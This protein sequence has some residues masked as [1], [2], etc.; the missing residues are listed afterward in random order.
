[1]QTLCATGFS[2]MDIIT[3]L[4]RVVR[5]S[6]I[7][8]FVKL[9]YLKEI[10]FCHMRVADGVSSQLQLTGLLAKLATH[11]LDV[12]KKRYQVAGLQR[13]LR[14]AAPH[15]PPLCLLA[16]LGPGRSGVD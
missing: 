6:D 14:C 4:F 3:T 16:T 8:E 12:A 13:S 7:R 1:M 15:A 5:N 2:A 10:G 9:E 11:P